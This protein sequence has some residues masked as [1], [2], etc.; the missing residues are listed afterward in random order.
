MVGMVGC[1]KSD[2]NRFRQYGRD[3]S[4]IADIRYHYSMSQTKEKTMENRQYWSGERIDDLNP[5]EVFVFGSNPQARHFA[6]AA[7]VAMTKFGAVPRNPAKGSLGIARGLSP[8]NRSYA[9]ITKSLEAGYTE[10]E[11]GITYPTEGFRS[12]SK[13]QIERNIR[14]LYAVASRQEH[15]NRKF[16]IS[17]TYDVWP[18]GSPKKSLNG[19]T[20]DEMARFFIENQNIPPN[21]VFH[22]SYKKILAKLLDEGKTRF[23]EGFPQDGQMI[24]NTNNSTNDTTKMNID[25]KQTHGTQKNP[26]KTNTTMGLPENRQ[27]IV[28][29][30]GHSNPFSNL[31]PAVFRVYD[32]KFI[33]N[34]QFI[35]HEKAAIF[36]DEKI[37]SK[38][39]EVNDRP[40][41]KSLIEGK[42]TAQEIIADKELSDEWKK[43]MLE[44]K[45]MGRSVANYDENK[46][47]SLR[48]KVAFRGSYEKFSQ[49]EGIQ[50]ALLA[51]SGSMLAESNKYDRVWGIGLWVDEAKNMPP[52][53][54]PGENMMGRVLMA[55][56]GKLEKTLEEQKNKSLQNNSY[57]DEPGINK[58]VS[59]KSSEIEVLNIYHLNKELPPGSIYIG[60]ENK[61]LGLNKSIY[62]NPF[63]MQESSNEE[64]M[65]VV[66]KFKDWFWSKIADNSFTQ[67]MLL[68]LKGKKLVCFC[69]P[70]LCHGH[71][72]QE[73]V[74]MLI[75]DK[76]LFMKTKEQYNA[77]NTQPARF[78]KNN[79]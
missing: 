15:Q 12:V 50:K 71:V 32:K 16:L 23:L 67:D 55:V 1:Q 78:P 47:A 26:V 45:S 66:E 74:N 77:R 38:V 14:E 21:I 17:Y 25:E 20:S 56:R 35:M 41:A 10:P 29:F 73:A 7:K 28:F 48:A 34:E 36:G 37:L 70:K 2:R 43:M 53:S 58:N 3:F 63:A 39:M 64:R 30:I 62:A 79:L 4:L 69:A 44:I 61:K 42:I 22:D 9:L 24:I 49:N 27:N 72:I 18:N 8:N 65:Y 75:N 46:W 33:S 11:T 59:E 13:E 76:E 52:S 54:W 60:R 6:G 51:T 19:Y 68:S 57:G 5:G 40:L 31:H